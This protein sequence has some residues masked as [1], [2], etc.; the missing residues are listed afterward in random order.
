MCSNRVEDTFV[1]HEIER[2]ESTVQGCVVSILATALSKQLTSTAPPQKLHKRRSTTSQERQ[3]KRKLEG[4]WAPDKARDERLT[5]DAARNCPD[6]SIMGKP[7]IDG[8]DSAAQK[9]LGGKTFV[10]PLGCFLEQ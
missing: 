8:L 3:A 4:S 9:R 1:K 5:S 7:A 6:S 10:G 2:Q